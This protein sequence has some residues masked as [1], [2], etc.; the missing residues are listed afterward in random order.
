MLDGSLVIGSHPRSAVHESNVS[1]GYQRGSAFEVVQLQLGR[2]D[3]S[4][5]VDQFVDPAKQSLIREDERARLQ[6]RSYCSRSS[7]NAAH[8]C[9]RSVHSCD[10]VQRSSPHTFPRAVRNALSQGHLVPMLN[11]GQLASWVTLTAETHSRSGS[12][13][14]DVIRSFE[15]PQRH[16]LFC[17]NRVLQILVTHQ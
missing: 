12:N 13:G 11:P 7:P 2:P 8:A 15:Y 6:H 16:L 17:M 4:R 5:F 3:D 1:W 9:E 14:G 10:L